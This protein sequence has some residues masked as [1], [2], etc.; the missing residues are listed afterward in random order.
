M[1]DA[2]RRAEAA[3]AATAAALSAPELAGAGLAAYEEGVAAATAGLAGRAEEAAKERNA[4]RQQLDAAHVAERAEHGR[5]WEE[6]ARSA[7]SQLDANHAALR[8]AKVR[9]TLCRDKHSPPLLPHFPTANTCGRLFDRAIPCACRLRFWM[10]SKR[11]PTS[12]GP[13]CGLQYPLKPLRHRVM[14][15]QIC[16]SDHADRGAPAAGGG[17]AAG[18]GAVAGGQGVEG[19]GRG[20]TARTV[21]WY[22]PL[23]W[24]QRARGHAVL[25]SG[26][27]SLSG[28]VSGGDR[29]DYKH[30]KGTFV[31]RAAVT[32]GTASSRAQT[33]TGW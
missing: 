2:I 5:V 20:G 15:S 7:R 22:R 27:V 1:Q 14:V 24:G 4:R 25:G 6:Q 11:R 19:P 31:G 8:V 18:G 23:A 21:D 9:Q 32:A 16:A 10:R 26:G 30:L 28:S 12:S 3:F 29:P 17:G 13:R 33:V